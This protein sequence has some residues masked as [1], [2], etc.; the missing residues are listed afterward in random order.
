[1]EMMF[2]MRFRVQSR[3]ETNRTVN[4]RIYFIL[5]F[6][7]VFGGGKLRKL[8]SGLYSFPFEFRIFLMVMLMM[9]SLLCWTWISV[10]FELV[11]NEEGLNGINK[12]FTTKCHSFSTTNNKDKNDDRSQY[13]WKHCTNNYRNFSLWAAM[14]IICLYAFFVVFIGKGLELLIATTWSTLLFWQ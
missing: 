3:V 8:F 10:F 14:F 1:M 6:Y 11:S 4:L 5:T 2:A 7:D 9:F 12:V 13:R